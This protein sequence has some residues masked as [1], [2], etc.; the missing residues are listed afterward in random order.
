MK[1]QSLH[2]DIVSDVVCPWC[3]IGY[4]RLE[5]ALARYQEQLSYPEQFSIDLNWQPFELNSKM[6]LGGQ[7]LREHLTEKYGA[8]SNGSKSIR[9][10]L[11]DLGASLNFNFN[12]FDEMRIYNTF[13]AHQLLYWAHSEGK[14]TELQQQLFKAYFSDQQALD[15]DD[16]LIT[17]A[18]SVGLKEEKAAAVLETQEFAEIVRKEQSTWLAHGIQAVPAFIF[19]GRRLLSGAQEVEVLKE[20]IEISMTEL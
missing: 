3:V 17:A 20:Q 1:I 2:I 19:N 16:V 9:Q 11:T 12:F 8:S 14:Q 4:K 5:Q 18:I 6:P 7:N 10:Q 15:Q 13:K